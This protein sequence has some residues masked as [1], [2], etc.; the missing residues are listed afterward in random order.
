MDQIDALRAALEISPDNHALRLVLADMLRS[1]G[2]VGEA[3][4]HYDVLLSTNHVPPTNLVALGHTAL[5]AG[6]TDLGGR[7]LASARHAGVIEGVAALQAAFDKALA[8]Q[9]VLKIALPRGNSTPPAAVEAVDERITFADVGGLDAVKQIIHRMIILPLQRPDL[10][11]KYG[12]RGGGG[13]VLYGP[14]GCGKTLLAR[15]TAG[16]CD[17]PFFN[18][19]IEDILDPYHGVSERNLHEAFTLV[20]ANAPCVVF[21]DELDAL[22]YARRKQSGN[23]GRSLVDQMLQEL[24]GIGSDNTQVLVLGATN[25]P[26]DVDDALL[27]PGRFDRRI[28]VPPPDDAARQQILKLLLAAVPT[29]KIDY[30]RLAKN[31]PLFSGADLRAVVERAVD[32]VIEEALVSGQEPPLTMQHIDEA[33]AT[34]RPTVLDWLA[35]A[36]N[37]VEF[38][39]HDERYKEVADFLRSREARAWKDK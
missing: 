2:R 9:G 12:R 11:Q 27:R 3:L 31:M 24:D 5:D 20:R 10:Y 29:H 6:N 17:L 16:E 25:A 38:A 37:Y 18:I 35:R 4:P 13:V 28:F 1:A 14:P 26:W 39:N 15:A 21:F 19:R 30:G 8:E 7:C 33:R 34:L 23:V 36:R 22:A 32:Q